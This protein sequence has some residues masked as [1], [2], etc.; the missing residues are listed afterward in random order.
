MISFIHFLIR[1]LG[2]AFCL[3]FFLFFTSHALGE[4]RQKVVVLGGIKNQGTIFPWKKVNHIIKSKFKEA[5]QNEDYDLIIKPNAT[6]E[7]LYVYLNSPETIALYWISHSAAAKSPTDVVGLSSGA[8]AL[9]AD[10]RDVTPIFQKA[11]SSVKIIGLIGCESYGILKNLQEGEY[12]NHRPDLKFLVFFEKVELSRAIDFAIQSTLPL[13]QNKE[14]LNSV[15]SESEESNFKNEGNLTLQFKRSASAKDHDSLQVILNNHFVTL[16]PFSKK[17]Q[18]QN[19]KIQ[20][21]VDFL[22]KN[23]IRLTSGF[24][25]MSQ[26]ALF[27]GKYE[28]YTLDS[29][30]ILTRFTLPGVDQSQFPDGLFYIQK[31]N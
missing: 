5:F 15:I 25:I 4:S 1:K 18:E 22:R 3:S 31:N 26:K 7:D 21:S 10:G 20:L 13:L 9:D 17:L 11:S 19:F 30:F 8:V 29:N 27:P 6:Q 14:E 12:Y 23:K 24:S 16:I 2:Y 28:L